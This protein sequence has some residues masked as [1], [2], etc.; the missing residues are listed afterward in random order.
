MRLGF[1]V[2]FH[3]PAAGGRGGAGV[4]GGGLVDAVEPEGGAV[5]LVGGGE[6]VGG[7]S[8]S[9]TPLPQVIVNAAVTA[10]TKERAHTARR[11]A[12]G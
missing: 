2:G 10:A 7:G 6:D 8:A 11:P 1:S 3:A 5:L 9:A 4:D 12:A